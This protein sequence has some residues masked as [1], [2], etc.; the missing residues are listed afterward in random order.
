[1]ER[2][3]SSHI[4]EI[5]LREGYHSSNPTSHSKGHSNN[6]HADS[7]QWLELIL[8]P[9]SGM[10]GVHNITANACQH[11]GQQNSSRVAPRLFWKTGRN[12]LYSKPVACF[13]ISPLESP[14]YDRGL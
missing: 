3:L 11:L 2:N 6:V 14:N 7:R 8:E 9:N 5:S 13:T 4:T 12:F 1:M 10:D